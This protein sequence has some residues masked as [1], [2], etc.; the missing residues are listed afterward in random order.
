M[1][2]QRVCVCVVCCRRFSLCVLKDRPCSL[3]IANLR[4]CL[5]S[6]IVCAAFGSSECEMGEAETGEVG[7]GPVR[8][9]NRVQVPTL[10]THWYEDTVSFSL[11]NTDDLSS[12]F[13]LPPLPLSFP[14]FFPSLPPSLLS[15]LPSL[16][17]SS[18]PPSLL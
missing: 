16:S 5:T 2:G 15:L 10:L 3:N 17:P 13:S 11:L 6:R 9:S 8:D 18:L 4:G 12:S 1:V 14:P 7:T